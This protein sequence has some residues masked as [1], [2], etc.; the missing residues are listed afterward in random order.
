[1]TEVESLLAQLVEIPSPN[2]PGDTRKIAAFVA[3]YLTLDGTSVQ[4]L[5]PPDKPEAASV[6]ARVGQGA[7][8]VIVL[9]AHVDTVPIGADEERQWSSDPYRARVRDGRMYGKGSVD[10]KAPL[11]A[12]MRVFRR[13][14]REPNELDGQLVL[15][16]AAEEEVGGQLG[17][18]WLADHDHIPEADFIIVGEQTRNRA[19]VAHKGVVRATISVNG[20]SV[21]ATN[22]DRGVNAVVAMA[23]ILLALQAYHESLAKRMHPLVGV[24][25]CNVGTIVGG[26]TANAVPDSCTIR[27]DRRMIPGEAPEDVE[28]ELRHVVQG[29][30]IGH[31]VATV[32]GILVSPWFE[33]KLETNLGK[34]F[35][36]AVAKVYDD[37]A[38]PVGYLPGSDA[39]H[40]LGVAR[41]G[42]VVFGP[43]SYE[44]AHASDE[45]VS[46]DEL[47]DCDRILLDFLRCLTPSKSGT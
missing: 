30:D 45:Y 9:H 34:A 25:T 33:S 17:T 14:A 4:T 42:I 46:L 8:P 29:V 2:P 47:A 40:L 3:D 23:K 21:H 35:L 13:L 26:S 1:M 43:G 11:A 22:P 31:A 15:V 28:A 19:A 12:M 16:A 41:G 24:P 6:I 27:L 20:R 18:R 5:Y 36:S 32:D 38:E 44:V 39:K 10:D 7:S 37:G